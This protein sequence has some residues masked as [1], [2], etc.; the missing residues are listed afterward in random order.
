MT[1]LWVG[2]DSPSSRYRHQS[3]SLLPDCPLTD[4]NRPNEPKQ[5]LSKRP[6]LAVLTV[7][8]AGDLGEASSYDSGARATGI[9]VGEDIVLGP[10]SYHAPQLGDDQLQMFD[11]VVAAEQLLLQCAQLTLLRD[12]KG[13]QRLFDPVCLDLMRVAC[14]S[15]WQGVCHKYFAAIDQSGC[16]GRFLSKASKAALASEQPC[17]W[18]LGPDEA[19]PTQSLLK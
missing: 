8:A 5:S 13:L 17:R 7:G 12:D 9:G 19:A 11:L 18:S 10:Q 1:T 15:P 16:A 14:A 4:R 3:G 6:V 2:R